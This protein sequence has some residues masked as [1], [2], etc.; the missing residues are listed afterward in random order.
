MYAKINQKIKYFL[1]LLIILNFNFSGFLFSGVKD[2]I[3]SV[4]V[5]KVNSIEQKI[6]NFNKLTLTGNVEVLVDNKL[7]ILADT[8]EIDKEKQFLIAKKDISGAVVIES[9]DLLILADEFFLNIKDKSGHA[10]NLNISIPQGYIS[11]A[12]AQRID[13][14]NWK[15][16]DVTFTSCDGDIP[17]WSLSAKKA[18]LYNNYLIKINGALFKIGLMPFFA[19]PYFVLPLQKSSSSGFLLP[20]IAYDNDLGFGIKQE[21]YWSIAPRFDSTIGL[22]WRD[23]K[24]LA[25]LDEFRWARS[26]E[27]FTLVNLR[28]ALEKNAFVK[29]KDRILLDTYKHYWIDGQDFRSIKSVSGKDIKAL[30]R[31]DFGTDKKIGYQFFDNYLNVDD[32]FLNSAILRYFN[33]Y[34]IYNIYFDSTQTRRSKFTDLTEQEKQDLL[35]VLPEKDKANIANA[36]K[37]IE[38]KFSLILLPRFDF[39]TINKK[40]FKNL[41]IRHDFFVDQALSRE[42]KQEKFYLNS[43][44]VKENELSV[45]SKADSFRLFYNMDILA[46]L[47]VKEQDFVI[48]L[49]PNFQLRSKVKN[50]DQ[51]V[52]V[53]ILEGSFL[54]D[55]AYRFLLSGGSEWVMP[56]LFFVN[57][58]LYHYYLQPNLKWHYIPKFKQDNWYH[59]DL[60]DRIYPKNE[61][62]LNL[63]NSWSIDKVN[64]DLNLYQSIDFYN[65]SD[66]FYLTRTPS[67]KNIFPLN[68]DLTIDCDVLDLFLKQEYDWK[69]FQ[70]L[71]SQI[72]L[73]FN[74]KD[75]NFYISSVFQH[76]KLQQAREL[77]SD[78]PNFLIL[79]LSVPLIKNTKFSYEG[80]FYSK[81]SSSVLPME[82]LK[83]LQHALKLHYNGHCWGFSL[84]YEEKRYKE[85]GNWKSDKAFTLFLRLDSLG[86]FARKFKRP[87]ILSK[88]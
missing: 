16:Q 86:S 19:L 67:E 1:F 18:H 55:G 46:N 35:V 56:E 84:G 6:D 47:K 13:D 25:L 38:D 68:F 2:L 79:S 45:F 7:H 10:K 8:I 53:N 43:K 41:Y 76:K 58:D 15:M 81:K 31:V 75:F 69:N 22:D 33:N 72:D 85:Y 30:T 21:F 77:L 50:H 24:G 32:T 36:Q 51:D 44:V 26:T 71:T 78:I 59:S 70:L 80:Q 64:I 14:Y 88:T 63:K 23:K 48:F 17:H 34:N 29:K 49:D 57:N 87:A 11:A 37:E 62:Q 28:Y 60:W 74:L 54:H 83:P 66:R 20:K 27:S 65:S 9:D 52:N 39:N 3:E 42:K 82:G 5:I 40:I 73:S 61:I 12:V 4:K